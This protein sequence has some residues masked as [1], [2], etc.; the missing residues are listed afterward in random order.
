MND[1]IHT[2]SYL[3]GAG[4]SFPGLKCP[5]CEADHLLHP[6]Q[7]Q[8]SYMSTPLCAFTVGTKTT[9]LLL[10]QSQRGGEVTKNTLKT[11]CVLKLCSLYHFFYFVLQTVHV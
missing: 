7:S 8:G 6:V 3:K 9:S 10:Y 1:Y 5:R 2:A 4:G 11:M